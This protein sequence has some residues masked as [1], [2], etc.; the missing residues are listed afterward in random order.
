MKT[1]ILASALTLANLYGQ[2]RHIVRPANR[3]CISGPCS[4][5]TNWAADLS[6]TPDTRPGTWGTA[7][8]ITGDWQF[9][10]V[11][12]GY[13]VRVLCVYGDFIAWVH[14]TVPAGTHAGVLWG[15]ETTAPE[16]GTHLEFGSD[17]CFMYL[18]GSVGD[19]DFRAPFDQDVRAGGLL[20]P[21][22]ILRQKLAVW[23]NDTGQSVHMEATMVVIYRFEGNKNGA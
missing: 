16:V 14:G 15:L 4:A 6:G 12:P 5:S 18:Q 20:Q 11:P 22:N 2:P 17:D 9:D 3:E 13:R 21:D 7:G 23:L 8:A 19:G 10:D 1:V